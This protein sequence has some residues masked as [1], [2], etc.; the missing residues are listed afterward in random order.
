MLKSLSL[1]FIVLLIYAH[2]AGDPD[3]QIAQ[4]L[5]MFRD[6]E[7]WLLGY[8]LFAVL[9]LLGVPMIHAL[10]QLRRD[11]ATGL[12]SVAAV[13]LALVAVTPSWDAFHVLASLVLIVLLYGYY[14]HLLHAARSAGLLPHLAAPVLLLFATQFHSYGAWQKGLIVYFVGVINVHYHVL[15]RGDP[16]SW[17]GARRR[18]ARPGPPF[19]RRKV[20]IVDP[21]QTWTRGRIGRS[22]DLARFGH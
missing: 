9:L 17:L 4:P 5:S 6:G 18:A 1:L 10:V 19:R 21:E 16:G 11:S 15:C 14:A 20:Y 12:F 2:D 13:L 8:S 22:S 3:K 7:Q